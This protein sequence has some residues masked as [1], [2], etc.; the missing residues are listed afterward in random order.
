M[1]YTK[2]TFTSGQI[3]K[4]SDLNTMSEGITSKQD[5]LV[6]GT[7][8]KTINGKSLLGSGD[9]P[10]EGGSG[11]SSVSQAINYDLNVKAINHRGYSAESPENTIPAYIMS[12]Q[13]GFTYVECDVSFTSIGIGD[14]DPAKTYYA[15]KITVSK[16]KVFNYAVNATDVASL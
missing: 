12:K 9:I 16:F 7:N 2:Q 4:A 15:D 1:A 14:N 5:T 8:L 13:K 6:S 10:I 11:G 3:L